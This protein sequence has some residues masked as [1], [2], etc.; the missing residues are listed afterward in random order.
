MGGYMGKQINFITNKGRT[1]KY[2]S[3]SL[4][5]YYSFEKWSGRGITDCGIQQIY[6]NEFKIVLVS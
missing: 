6:Y 1:Y 3:G 2:G 5:T 4:G